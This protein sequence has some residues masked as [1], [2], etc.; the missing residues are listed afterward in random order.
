[1]HAYL[2]IVDKLMAYLVFAKCFSKLTDADIIFVAF[3]AFVFL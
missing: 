3:L 2:N 1:M